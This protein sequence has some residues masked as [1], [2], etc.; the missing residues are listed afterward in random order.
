MAF[1][2]GV[3]S[4]DPLYQWQQIVQHRYDQIHPIFHTWLLWALTRVG[5]SFGTVS[6][7]QVLLTAV[8]L[9]HGF[10]AARRVGAPAWLTWAMAAWV[11]V[12]PAYGRNVI[13][14][15]KD[16]PFGIATLG[17][18]LVLLRAAEDGSLGPT[19][20]TR[21]GVALACMCLLRPNGAAV[22]LPTFALLAGRFW[23][24]SRLEVMRAGG[25][26]LALVVIV[27]IAAHARGVHRAPPGVSQQ[28]L[29]QPIA[30][31]VRAGTAMSPSDRRALEEVAPVGAWGG[32]TCERI[33]QALVY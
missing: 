12:S 27:S 30:A 3:V 7:V 31:L 9:G 32:C 2:P 28:P 26:C 22:A 6:L 19:H 24:G 11:A 16:N 23:R 17:A 14:V 20:A 25:L 15:W 1:F 13:A 18:A 33:D 29:I 4:N 21:L 8:L 5:H 10:A